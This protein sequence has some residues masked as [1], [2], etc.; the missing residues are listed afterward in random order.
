MKVITVM[1]IS[2]A[3]GTHSIH[4][5]VGVRMALLVALDRTSFTDVTATDS[6]SSTS[7]STIPKTAVVA[8]CG[9]WLRGNARRDLTLLYGGWGSPGLLVVRVVPHPSIQ[10]LVSC[11]RSSFW[12]ILT[13]KRLTQPLF[14]GDSCCGSLQVVRSSWPNHWFVDYYSYAVIPVVYVR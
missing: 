4:V 1:C 10:P 12:N 9:R 8:G 11:P 2:I 3:G 7:T 14:L 5:C 6:T 13:F